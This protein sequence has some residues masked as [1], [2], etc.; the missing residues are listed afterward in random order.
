MSREL[1]K[2]AIECLHPYAYQGDLI[3]DADAEELITAIRAHLDNTNGVE[4]KQV[5]QRDALLIDLAESLTREDKL[6]QK[7][8]KLTQELDAQVAASTEYVNALSF[9]RRDLAAMTQ[10]RD[11]LIAAN[12][13]S[14]DG[15][16]AATRLL[17]ES[18]AREQQFRDLLCR[19]DCLASEILQEEIDE[20]LA[21]RNDT[22]ALIRSNKLYAAGV[23]SKAIDEID[24]T[25]E[26]LEVLRRMA[27]QLR[28]EAE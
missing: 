17:D 27:A 20:I 2:Q 4:H 3:W 16:Q 1:L 5:E 13:A 10:E 18:Q 22:T 7:V 8:E 26:G 9:A 28:K 6:K 11:V 23:L 15:F 12:R 24:P 19:A 25:W 21:A 14:Y